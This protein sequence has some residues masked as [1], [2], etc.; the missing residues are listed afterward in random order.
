MTSKDNAKGALVDSLNGLLAD[1]LALYIKTKN[2]H[3]HVKGAQFHDLHLLFDAQAGQILALTDVVAERVRKQGGKTLTSPDSVV[4][5]TRVKPQ[6]STDLDAMAMVKEL[7]DDNVAY[8]ERLREVKAAAEE[9]GDNA[10][11]GI[12]DDW[13]DQ[14]EERA[15]FLREILA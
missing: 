8:I 9:A 4:A 5:K 2:F 14:A 13:T 12:V 1:T 3:W 10:T 7:H 6:D 15:W 11:D